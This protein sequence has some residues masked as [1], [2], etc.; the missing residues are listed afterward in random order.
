MKNIIVCCDGTGNQYGTNNIDV[1][2]A[3]ALAE[4]S[5]RQCRYYD[6]GIGTGGWVY[7]EDHGTLRAAWIRRPH[8][9]RVVRRP[10]ST[11][12]ASPRRHIGG[13]SDIGEA[14]AQGAVCSIM[15]PIRL[16][17]LSVQ[18]DPSASCQM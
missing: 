1:A 3:Y 16:G 10:P 5:V 11:P 2:A 17:M 6:P 18:D 9:P 14:C 8:E 12:S 15:Y 13:A 7:E 4:E